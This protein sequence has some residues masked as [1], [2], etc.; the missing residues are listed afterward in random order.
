MHRPPCSAGGEG[1]S[2]SSPEVVERA[3]AIFAALADPT[4]FRIL[5][6]LLA[7]ELTVSA[8]AESVDVTASAVSHQLR[9]LRDRGLVA[10]RRDG[11][12]VLYHLHDHHIANLL[13]QGRIHAHHIGEGR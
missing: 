3:T 5:E 4:R 13:E 10:S 8:I 11:R 7:G 12:N 2:K 9:L 6:S 1:S